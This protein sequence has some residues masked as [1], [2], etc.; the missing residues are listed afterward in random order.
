MKKTLMW[1]TR[2]LADHKDSLENQ[3]KEDLKVHWV[4][5]ER[6]CVFALVLR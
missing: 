1:W 5:P 3:A 2:D 4:R 6:R